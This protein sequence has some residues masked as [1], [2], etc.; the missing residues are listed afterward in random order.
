MEPFNFSQPADSRTVSKLTDAL[1]ARFP[2]LSRQSLGK[3]VLGKPIDCLALSRT[4]ETPTSF[5]KPGVLF[6]AAFHA[7]EWLTS[8]IL[9]QLITEFCAAYENGAR[10]AGLNPRRILCDRDLF[11][12]P[13]VN[14]DGVDV[15][16]HGHAAAG[17]REA[18]VREISPLGLDKWNANLHGVDLNHNFDAGWPLLRQ[19][20]IALGLTGPAP[21]RFGGTAPE[22]EP[23]TRALADFC[24]Q[25]YLRHAL[26]LH[27]QGEEI[28][29]HYGPRTPS[30]AR[31]MGNLL[32]M[33]SG[34]TLAQPEDIASHGGFK[35][36]FIS[37]FG[38]P[39]FTVEIGR[40]QNP[41]P[42]PDLQ[43][44][45]ARICEMLMLA[46]VI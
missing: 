1:C 13:L 11:F 16:I 23:E 8:L 29:W 18:F 21:R 27:S 2:I 32:A 42:L 36:W 22:S 39:A 10:L 43:P 40:G 31:L 6:A 30:R 44:I 15:A 20:E 41:L 19:K 28:Y 26:A 24:R 17:E 25:H 33:S 4:K 37:C 34:Y 12:V 5:F 35:D 3:S 45:Y 14:P 46:A 9:L 38:R 7:Q